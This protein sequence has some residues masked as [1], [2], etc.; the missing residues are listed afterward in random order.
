[1]HT[2]HGSY[3][4]VE[5]AVHHLDGRVKILLAIMMIVFVFLPTGL[6]GL[7]LLLG[8]VLTI[9][10]IAK[11]PL[12]LFSTVF[13][14]VLFF[15]IFVLL[16]NGFFIKPDLTLS[17]TLNH[18]NLG[19]TIYSGGGQYGGVEWYS[20]NTKSILR[21][22]YISLRIGYV[23]SIILI[24]T[25]TT[26]SLTLTL[27]LQSLLRP[28]GY[29]KIPVK[30]ISLIISLGLQSIPLL[31]QEF[32]K[33]IK[34]QASR[35][36]DVKSHNIIKKIKAYSSVIIPMFVNSL[37]RSEDLSLAMDAKGFDIRAKRSTYHRFHLHLKDIIIFFIIFTILILITLNWWNQ[38]FVDVSTSLTNYLNNPNY[39]ILNKITND[40]SFL[41]FIWFVDFLVT[42]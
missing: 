16:I 39:L 10:L 35:G 7:L 22:L 20:I 2:S 21:A 25:S 1:M 29:L 37:K 24:L 23:L 3:L 13:K 19:A 15:F 36:I 38:Q 27:A 5:T 32:H 41:R 30:T 34:A 40:Q 12:K 31:S 4:N 8:L 28:L 42:K 17:D 11:I 26:K 33:V 14:F 9:F 18:Q 6:W